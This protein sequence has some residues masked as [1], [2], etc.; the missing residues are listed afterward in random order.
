MRTNCLKLM[1]EKGVGTALDEI[2]EDKWIS[3]YCTKEL[4][5]RSGM[6]GCQKEHQRTLQGA[7]KKRHQ[8][9]QEDSDTVSKKIKGV[10]GKPRLGADH[11][12]KKRGNQGPRTLKDAPSEPLRRSFWQLDRLRDTWGHGEHRRITRLSQKNPPKRRIRTPRWLLEDS[13]TLAENSVPAKSRKH[14][15]KLQKRHLSSAEKKPEAGLQKNNVKSSENSDSM[16]KENHSRQSK[17]YP[18]DCSRSPSPPVILE[19][20]LPD[21]ELLG[22]FSEDTYNRQRGFPQVLLYK[23][24]VKPATP[25]P[26]KTVHGKEVV[27]RARDPSMFVQQLHCYARRPKGKGN[28]LSVQSSVSTITRSSA[29]GSPVKV[30]QRRLCAGS[31]TSAR[32][33]EPPV[34]ENVLQTKA[35]RAGPRRT[36]API[37]EQPERSAASQSSSVAEEAA[38]VN[39]EPPVLDKFL[40][41]ASAEKVVANKTEEQLCRSAAPAVLEVMEAPVL[42]KVQQTQVRECCEESAVEMKVTI[43]S[44]SPAT[45]KAAQPPALEKTSKSELAEMLVEGGGGGSSMVALNE[46]ADIVDDTAAG[47][48]S[49]HAERPLQSNGPHAGNVAPP[50]ISQSISE[51]VVSPKPTKSE[52]SSISDSSPPKVIGTTGTPGSGNLGDISALTLVTEM[53]T[54]LTQETQTHKM[55][56]PEDKP[57]TTSGRSAP[58]PSD[59]CSDDGFDPELNEDGEAVETEESRLEYCCTFCNKVFKGSRVIAHAMF[60]YRKDECMFCGTVFRDDLL[61]MMHLSDHIEKLKRSK[62][63]PSSK[64]SAKSGNT[65]SV[66]RGRGRRKKSDMTSRSGSPLESTTTRSQKLRS[67]GKPTVGPSSREKKQSTPGQRRSPTP[68]RLNGHIDKKRNA[69]AA[70]SGARELSRK[71]SSSVAKSSRLQ[72]NQDQGDSA[73]ASPQVLQKSSCAIKAKAETVRVSQDEDGKVDDTEPQER[74]CCP[75]DGCAWFADSSRNRVSLLYHALDQHPG[76]V[77]PL[78]L[79]FRVGSSKCSIC[80]RVMWSFDHFLHHVEGHRES[81]RYP[82]LHRG[83]TARFKTGIE[84]RRHTRKHS[85]LQATCCVPGCSQLF[86]CLWALNLHEKEHYASE[87]KSQASD[88]HD[89]PSRKRQLNHAK[90]R[91]RTVTRGRKDACKSRGRDRPPQVDHEASSSPATTVK[92]STSSD[93][94]TTRPRVSKSSSGKDVKARRAA[95]ILRLRRRFGKFQV[96]SKNHKGPKSSH[97]IAA[98]RELMKRQI[99]VNDSNPPR[100]RGRPPKLKKVAQ[101]SEPVEGAPKPE[102]AAKVASAS[103]ILSKLRE[104]LRKISQK[105]LTQAV[106]TSCKEASEASADKAE[107]LTVKSTD[108]RPPVEEISKAVKIQE[109][110]QATKEEEEE[111][112]TAKANVVEGESNMHNAALEG[113]APNA[114]TTQEVAVVT[115]APL[116]TLAGNSEKSTSERSGATN[117]EEEAKSL[118]APDKN[119]KK[120]KSTTKTDGE[121]VR[122]GRPPTSLK[123]L[124]EERSEVKVAAAEL[125]DGAPLT[126]AAASSDGPPVQKQRKKEKKERKKA[127]REEKEKEEQQLKKKKKSLP[128]SPDGATRKRRDAGDGRLEA[129]EEKRK[130]RRLT[131][132][133]K[134]PEQSHSKAAPPLVGQE[135]VRRSSVGGEEVTST[136]AAA[137]PPATSSAAPSVPS[138]SGPVNRQTNEGDL[139]NKICMETLAEYSKKPYLRPPPNVYLDEKYTAMPKRRK[140]AGLGAA[141]IS[142]PPQGGRQDSRRTTPGVPRRLRCANCFT[143][144]CSDEELQR[145]LEQRRCANLF[146][147]DSDEEVSLLLILTFF[148]Y[149]SFQHIRKKKKIV[150]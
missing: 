64:T 22:S 5:L 49:S 87:A 94:R 110:K 100:K 109:S 124:A 129:T 44:N 60:H 107:Q 17:K 29:Q 92:A 142:P 55:S 19:L 12:A 125:A 35:A 128:K 138:P 106:S 66:R 80:M 28:G 20:S 70:N 132:I 2:M 72:E 13:G 21:N 139:K 34:L 15:L 39:V 123:R 85:P 10:P 140:E 27:L 59:G 23:H 131:A 36:P 41:D 48:S 136:V 45:G 71:R 53:V 16:A 74:L 113:E 118:L 150:R 62:D 141:P 134:E 133:A 78:K 11:A 119:T 26:A 135:E 54:E 30:P 82:C 14:K 88:K 137:A 104:K 65:S 93:R 95:P 79:A 76:E 73:Q 96:K 75:V 43:A 145:H 69:D 3:N 46:V 47:S 91:D 90:P 89:P 38:S 7:D 32:P 117:R 52:V 63:A 116:V 86:I 25:P 102:G 115:A 33:S 114:E 126:E 147:F 77:A 56:P 40:P 149:V 81:P 9:E 24:T 101:T 143:T 4:S 122:R 51:V 8:G 18:L 111:G 98:G 146:G 108:E 1:S 68:H 148:F 121:V 61:A 112:E 67:D 130:Y 103:S 120:P 6:V 105:A 144:F 57:Q 83:C 127:R 84:M 31:Q 58:E 97:A 37:E 42:E 99:E 50:K